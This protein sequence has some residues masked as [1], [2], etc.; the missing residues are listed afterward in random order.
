MSKSSLKLQSLF[1]GLALA[2]FLSG[3]D[4][5]E[6]VSAQDLA[7]AEVPNEAAFTYPDHP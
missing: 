7:P 3:C 2:L 4:L 5:I 6:P 1:A